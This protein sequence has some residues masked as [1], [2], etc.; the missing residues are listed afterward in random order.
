MRFLVSYVPTYNAATV[1]DL[2]LKRYARG[3]SAGVRSMLQLQ[4]QSWSDPGSAQVNQG[5]Y[6]DVMR[7]AMAYTTRQGMRMPL[8]TKAVV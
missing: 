5:I 7:G 6:E 8:R 1:P 2:L 4:R 3:F